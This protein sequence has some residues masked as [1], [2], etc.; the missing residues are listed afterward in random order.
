M[1]LFTK[2]KEEWFDLGGKHIDNG[3]FDKA[4]QAYHKALEIDNQD[5]NV[6]FNLGLSFHALDMLDEAYESFDM[7]TT[8]LP[9]YAEAFLRKGCVLYDQEKYRLAI[10]NINKSLELGLGPDDQVTA[11]VTIAESYVALEKWDDAFPY[12]ES[13]LELDDENVQALSGKALILYLNGD[14][15]EANEL[16]EEAKEIDS[17]NPALALVLSTIDLISDNENDND[18]REDEIE[19][20]ENE[21]KKSKPSNKKE[22]NSKQSEEKQQEP[23]KTNGKSKKKF[24]R[25]EEK[26]KSDEP[27]GF[28]CVAGMQELKD[29]LTKDVIQPLK[30]PEKFKKFNVTTPNGILLFGPP[31]CGKT[32]I[33]RKLAEEIGYNFK[34]ISPSGVGSKWAHETSGNIAKIFQDAKNNAPTILFFDEIEAL[35]P[36]RESL[37]ENASHRQEEIN[38]FLS[39]LND[40]SKRGILVVGATNQPDLIDSAIMRSGRMD[41]RIYVGPPDFAARS[42]LFRALLAKA[43]HSEDINYDK[44][45]EMTNNF[46]SSDIPNIVQDAGRK[47]AYDGLDEIEQDL[48][49]Y[50][51]E[52]AKPSITKSQIEGYEAF[53]HLERK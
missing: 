22:E 50:T 12:Y 3:D 24:Q 31:G 32:F 16:I 26:K 29:I 18:D 19:N 53:T 34:E 25:P 20:E 1:G 4:V 30:N 48:L 51:I 10:K 39:Q 42:E 52:K 17:E 6:W 45:A 46:C 21:I 13:A 27:I 28:A 41:K 44:L 36:K 49:E 35:V 14:K 23:V 47:A 2:T 5:Q 37:G 43:A 40:A 33:V 38:E 11:F 9:D 7:S 15:D 8:I